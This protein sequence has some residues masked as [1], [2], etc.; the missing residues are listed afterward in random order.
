MRLLLVLLLTLFSCGM[1]LS[2]AAAEPLSLTADIRHRPPEM[3]VDGRF[4]GGPLKTILEEAAN[5]IGYQ[6]NWRSVPFSASI[7]DL[8][9]GLTDVVPRTIRKAD[10]EAYIQFLGPIRSQRKEILFLVRAGNEQLIQNY[11]N[12]AKLRIGVKSKTAYFSQFDQDTTLN[13]VVSDGGDY[14]LARQLIEGKVD[15]VV[16]LDK[17]AMD[18]A[19]AGLGFKAYD[20]AQYRHI[21]TL[22]NYYGLS[23]HSANAHLFEPLNRT[24]KQMVDS[25][26][27]EEI[28]QKNQLSTPEANRS[29]TNLTVAEKQ[30]LADNPGPFLVHNEKDYPPFNYFENG[31]PKGFSIDYMNLLAKKL[32]ITIQYVTGPNWE[33][34]MEQLRDG[35]LDIMLNIVKTDKR[36]D[37]LTFTP[38]YAES[39]AVFVTRK[40]RQPVRNFDDL[41]GKQIAIPKGFFYQ[42]ILE[43]E[44]PEIQL[45]LTENL[46]ESLQA[47]AGGEAEA[48]LGGLA[49]ENWLIQKYSLT[50]L[51]IDRVVSN[52]LFSNAM[53][54]AVHNKK[55]LLADILSKASAK[56]TQEEY[57]ALQRKWFSGNT[58]SSQAQL[59]LEELEWI[60]RLD[61]PL[62][63]GSEMDWPPFDFVENGLATGFSNELLRAIAKEVGLPVTF[64]HGNTWAEI[65][66]QF[67]AG[68][69]DILPAL[70][71]T[72]ER[73][74]KFLYTTSYASNT[75]V[76]VIPSNRPEIQSLKDLGKGRIAIV[77]GF[78][79]TQLLT[80]RFPEI[81]Q[82][83]VSNALDGL[84]AVSL[85]K[86]D[87]F[88]GSYAVI[89]HLLKEHV[90]PN[91]HILSEVWLTQ[92]EERR[93]HISVK[94]EHPLL[95]SILQKGL[96]ALPSE[97]IATLHRYWLPMASQLSSNHQ[98]VDLTSAEK[99]WLKEHPILRLGDDFSWRPFSFLDKEG[100][101]SGISAGYAQAFSD[102][103][104]LIFR[105]V[106]GLKW[107]EVIAGIKNRELDIVPAV[108]RTPERD[109]FMLFTKP[110]LTFPVVIATRKNSPFVD[111]LDN[112][113][114]KRV[115]VVK[116]YAIETVLRK[117]H[118][119][120]NLMTAPTIEEGL[121]QLDEGDT[122]A[123]VDNLGAIT[124]EM[125]RSAIGNVKIAA[126]TSYQFDVSFGVRK[127]WPEL[128]TILNKALDSL[129]PADRAA[130]KN[131]WMAVTVQFGT[132][133]TT[134]L[135]WAVPIGSGLFLVLGLI[136]FWNRK[137]GR[138]IE[139][140][141]QV[142]REMRKLTLAVEKSP[143]VVIITDPEGRFEYVNPRF[144]E[145]TGYTQDELQGKTTQILD[146]G[147]T[148]EETFKEMWQTISAGHIWRGEIIN[149]KK[150]GDLYWASVSISPIL[151]EG[152]IVNFISLQED[153]T[154][155]KRSAEAIK[156]REE[157]LNLVLKGGD[158]GFW[159]VN[160][161]SGLTVV[162][163]RY[164]DIFGFPMNTMEGQQS[165]WL[166]RL[167]PEDKERVLETG[168]L[169]RTGV[170]DD[171]EI[172]YRIITE[173][174]EEKW[175]ISKGAAVSW[176]EDGTAQR[177]VG[178][179]QDVTERKTMEAALAESDER[180]RLILSS[181]TDGIFGLDLEGKTTFVNPAATQLLG[182]SE[183]EMVGQA[184]HDK[185]HHSYPNG[186]PYP[187]EDCHMRAAF[188]KGQLSQISDEVLWCQ[189]GSSLP[190][191]YSAVPMHKKGERVGAVVVFR[192]IRERLKA[193]ARL[194]AREQEFRTLIESAPDAMVIAD[195]QGIIKMVNRQTEQLFGYKREEML[196]QPVEMLIPQQF[197][198]A[199]PK[200][201]ASYQENPN[202]RPMGG[203]QELAALTKAGK[204]V[205]VE[206]SL[207]PIKTEQGLMIASSLR[208]ISA[209]KAADEKIREGNQ[210]KARV[211][212]VERFNRLA[213]DRETRILE[214]KEQ[215][216]AL[217]LQTGQEIP[218]P[219]AGP[220][221]QPTEEI[222]ASPGEE[223]SEEEEKPQISHLMDLAQM[224]KL[225]DNYCNS[226][227]IASAIIDLEGNI[228]AASRWQRAC[229]D[230]HRAKESSCA[231][232]IESDT[233]LSLKLD[234]GASFTL[235]S[236]KN[237]L[238][239][240]AA[241]I[242]INGEHLAN[243]FIGQ[244]LLKTPD[245]TFFRHQSEQ[246]GYDTDDYLQAIGDVPIIEEDKLPDILSFLSGFSQMVANLSLERYRA[247]RA[248]DAISRRAKD[249]QEERIAAM[250]LAEDAQ[251]ARAEIRRHQEHL[252]QLVEERTADLTQS[253]AHLAKAKE[254]A[255]EANQAKS[256]FLANMSHEIRTPMNAIIGMSYLALGTELT[257]RQRNYIQKVNR[258]A[259]SL[260]GIIN[261]ILDFSKIEAG[262]MD[263]ESID[264]RMEDVLDNLANLV[265]LKAEEKGVELLFDTDADA[266]M[267]LI[268]DPLRLGQILTNLGNNAVK[269]TDNGQIVVSS[270]M[271]QSHDGSA[272]F[273]FSVR[274]SGI[275]MTPEQQSKLFQ[276]F[277][278]A[279]SSTSRKYGGT[280][281]GLTISKRLTEM[282]GGK[283]W[284][285]SEAGVGSTFHFTVNLGIQSN[286]EERQ[287]INREE[288]VDLRVLVVDD[289]AF[290][291]E[292]LST[293]A[294][295]FGMEVD[296][297]P[298]GK[299]ALVAVRQAVDQKIPYDIV[300][301]DW[302]MPG[303][304]GIE[305]IKNMKQEM[306]QETPSVIM[307]TAYGRE[308]AMQSANDK[309]ITVNS[310]LTKPVT[311]SSLLDAI[312][313]TLGRGVV[314]N[315]GKAA[316]ANDHSEA[317]NH[318]RGAHL[319]LVDDNEINQELALE[320]FAN[321]GLTATSASNGQIALDKLKS[322]EVF[323]GVL[324]DIQMP[325]MDGYTAT[326]A[327][328]QLP[329]FKDLP[330][331]AM[332]A[333]VMS[334]D[335]EKA[336][337]AGMNDHI[338]K[339]IN[340]R[341]M[342]L[343][344]AKWITPANPVDAPEPL[345]S[346]SEASAAEEPF[347]P[348]E[349]IEVEEG[350]ARIGGN[351]KSYRKL[352]KKFYSNQEGVPEQIISALEQEDS[353]LAE[354]LAHTLK[355]V[356][357]SIGA[358]ALQGVSAS[359]EKAIREGEQAVVDALLPEATSKLEQVRDA[360]A[361]LE[362]E[363]AKGEAVQNRV[364][365]ATLMP[366]LDLLQERL[367]EDDIE[368]AERVE[369]ILEQLTGTPLA[370][371]L[372]K[373]E[374]AISGYDF[375]EALSQLAQLKE[376][377]ASHT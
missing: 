353:L 146:S 11:G 153:V 69:L 43:K 164:S 306:H 102:R 209:R 257:S 20:Y 271:E 357:G 333:N 293:M 241:P 335:L 95:L 201:R 277:S 321:G 184:M 124:Y 311:P 367:E 52:P 327:I 68:K 268:G 247:G 155:Q 30:W 38:P 372:Q 256:D 88:I 3:I 315:N 40:D 299:E 178:T 67:E 1:P 187:K 281:L 290:A 213:L 46:Q 272:L 49:I 186:T 76:V 220:E 72:P 283:I 276:S 159:D 96:N 73:M 199:H 160:L 150:N 251:Q 328:R 295:S 362:A 53:H 208:D 27:V 107:D 224:Q 359:L 325:V 375:D 165:Q 348:L 336:A 174:G 226:V 323:D 349:G 118:P 338:G 191:E 129:K 19:L 260:L 240:C 203:N 202:A 168:K 326:R 78:A 56:V 284:V 303:M 105:P 32:G 144:V 147:K 90:I 167:H 344:M 322:G 282:M 80:K 374:A 94:K 211:E 86:A 21:L 100:K 31:H 188:Q 120:L 60:R 35:R 14:A 79:T 294:V 158:L 180:S 324:M 182:F 134:I 91:L 84:R 207:S 197:Q 221:N 318:L 343:T 23:K 34:F 114:G 98:Q 172:E 51:R 9:T 361:T 358:T 249:L 175:V 109:E 81:E 179:V 297:V 37:Y 368:A 58:S 320:L 131:T 33:T 248:E 342:F 287:I 139:Q 310:I 215:V 278:Q 308:E 292:I 373:I 189:D 152:N 233:E 93:L 22:D 229:T 347:P 235:Y 200:Q 176:G 163:Q 17:A 5:Q 262:K 286:P 141:R 273:H 239:D 205:P 210:A 123:F 26:R 313:E 366:A 265:G 133:L 369:T 169:Y 127:D 350:L 130:I 341:E 246:F 317:L 143:S 253:Q 44:Y 212:E 151:V 231:R 266:P 261:D 132:D 218:Y 254:V 15:T 61:E 190:V 108:V 74:K 267:A 301:M 63:V 8:R 70:Y 337:E 50:N 263:M 161:D 264:F 55:A 156:E 154:E 65:I 355:G 192:D 116:G 13:R 71:R 319:L 181:V 237:G 10:R 97:K 77:E 316:A 16:V 334:G 346:E 304:D 255:E 340:V 363:P 113:V 194:R 331:I 222:L 173:E 305:C 198:Q 244:F 329:H 351:A 307:V 291:R 99:R 330:V 125:E 302:L 135:I 228:L 7:E 365:L 82:V 29:V 140:R 54:L 117:K 204:Q 196:E 230:F 339:P 364:D 106:V 274:D 45:L 195:E 377:L 185:V 112:L 28:F 41:F 227:E 269:F 285:E 234:E 170:L 115:G 59:T 75:S 345:A 62:R 4:Q 312:G 162:N 66:Q 206:I 103:L 314:R 157:R 110:Y 279:D 2:V 166:E 148:P 252:E 183:E 225:L 280:G 217:F 309:Q 300:F 47:V 137:M 171:Y 376:S 6:V 298:N 83:D 371:H 332:T 87:A 48:A 122:D 296:V 85:G 259:E 232:C 128:V 193:E 214:L 223:R 136:L 42:E 145:V 126:P 24:L 238:T 270:Q 177:M 142:E 245:M 138:E 360:I 57:T 236:C 104:E 89:N 370:S 149:R 216:N 219:V 119:K 111:H 352:L 288:L 121:K 64:I 242:V 18:S 39:P 258:S 12:L 25:G 101:H 36:S 289:N 356:A 243:V 92:P 250:S 275:G 354:R